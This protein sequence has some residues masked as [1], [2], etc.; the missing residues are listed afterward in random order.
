M[1][2]YVTML[3]GRSFSNERIFRSPS[4][5]AP[6][7]RWFDTPKVP[8]LMPLSTPPDENRPPLTKITEPS[9]TY[10][11]HP[12]I[13]LPMWYRKPIGQNPP[14]NSCSIV[15]GGED[16]MS[17]TQNVLTKEDYMRL[18]RERRRE[19]IHKN[20]GEVLGPIFKVLR[21]D[22]EKMKPCHREVNFEIPEHFDVDRTEAVL[23][24]Y[25][26]DLGYKPLT[27]VRKNSTGVTKDGMT[28]SKITLTLT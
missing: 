25:F 18:V 11:S 22:A 20:F 26:S 24:S 13:P 21:E 3:L 15:Y 1:Y 14:E 10:E 27:E 16:G 17:L 12:V 5:V 9:N 19:F 23:V 4:A 7:T 6:K 28:V 2:T 8:L